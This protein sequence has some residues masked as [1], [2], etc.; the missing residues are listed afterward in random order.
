M[1]ASKEDM[2]DTQVG[3]SRCLPQVDTHKHTQQYITLSVVKLFHTFKFKFILSLKQKQITVRFSALVYM[4]SSV[5]LDML[6]YG[7][8][9]L[10]KS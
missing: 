10:K 2:M 3:N 5:T 6:L 4:S 1:C 8:N 7:S 9:F